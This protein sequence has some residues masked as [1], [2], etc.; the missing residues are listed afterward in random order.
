METYIDDVADSWAVD[1]DGIPVHVGNGNVP[2]DVKTSGAVIRPSDVIIYHQTPLGNIK[3]SES[4]SIMEIG[5]LLRDMKKGVH[6]VPVGTI[7]YRPTPAP[8]EEFHESEKGHRR[9]YK[10]APLRVRH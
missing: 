8:K 6:Y 9:M 4:M 1:I 10:Q 3:F 2:N 7:P 5:I